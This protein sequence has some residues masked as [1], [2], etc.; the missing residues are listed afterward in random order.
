MYYI[1]E[2][3]MSKMITKECK[4]YLC[5][6]KRGPF[7]YIWNSSPRIGVILELSQNCLCHLML[8]VKLFELDG[9]EVQYDTHVLACTCVK[10]RDYTVKNGYIESGVEI[11]ESLRGRR[12]GI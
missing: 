5:L 11:K 7:K 1:L 9:D 2:Y 6:W 8:R 12:E 4:Q 3:P 10:S